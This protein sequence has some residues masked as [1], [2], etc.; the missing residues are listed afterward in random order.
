[1]EY[2]IV[3][4]SSETEDQWMLTKMVNHVA[5]QDCPEAVRFLAQKI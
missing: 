5:I 4:A 2:K 3:S 1:M